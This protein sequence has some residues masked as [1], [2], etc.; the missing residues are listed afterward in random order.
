MIANS[1]NIEHHDNFN[2]QL[3]PMH[4]QFHQVGTKI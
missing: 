1:E 2:K 4:K 3:G